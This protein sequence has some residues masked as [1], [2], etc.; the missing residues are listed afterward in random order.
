MEMLASLRWRLTFLLTWSRSS[1]STTAAAI[2]H[3]PSLL[4]SSS[5]HSS[6]M[7]PPPPTSATAIVASHHPSLPNLIVDALLVYATSSS[8]PDHMADTDLRAAIAPCNLLIFDLGHESPLWL[9]LNDGGLTIFFD[10]SDLHASHFEKTT[11]RSAETK[12]AEGLK[13]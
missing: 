7:P 5:T 12:S 3:H 13:R 9:T 11:A 6:S 2:S 4:D 1:T 8:H 10:Y